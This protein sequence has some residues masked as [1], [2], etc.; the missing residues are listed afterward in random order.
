M[1]QKE[2]FVVTHGRKHGGANPGMTE[3]GFEEVSSL[4]NLLPLP[5][6]CVVSGTGQRHLDVAEALGLTPNRYTAIVGGPESGEAIDSDVVNWVRLSDAKLVPG[7]LVPYEQYTTLEDSA[8]AAQALVVSLP[9]NS[10]V[11]AGRPSMI[12][13]GLVDAKSA[14]VY[15]ILVQDGKIVWTDEVRALGV[16]EKNAV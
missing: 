13:F 11:C 3:K 8:L 14:A 9:H 2:I 16:P 1:E 6:A 15:R 7:K 10:V 5:I 12:M 4:R